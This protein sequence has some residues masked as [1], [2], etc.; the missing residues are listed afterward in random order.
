MSVS[1]SAR[2]S[3]SV[4]VSLIVSS[5]ALFALFGAA[6]STIASTEG[7][8]SS[9]G[10]L[11]SSLAP[12]ASAGGCCACSVYAIITD[13]RFNFDFDFAFAFGFFV[14]SRLNLRCMRRSGRRRRGRAEN[15]SCVWNGARACSAE[16]EAVLLLL[17]AV[18]TA[19]A[20]SC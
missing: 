13:F 6:S 2:T 9:S 5:A 11:N 4:S 20:A 18:A 19:A 12:L 1:V 7:G 16:V 10:G 15:A 3:V 14:G 8:R 17:L